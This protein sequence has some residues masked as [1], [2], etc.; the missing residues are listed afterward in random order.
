[1]CQNQSE[2]TS[3]VSAWISG[4]QISCTETGSSAESD[5]QVQKVR[6]CHCC[7]KQAAST[8][9]RGSLRLDSSSENHPRVMQ[10]IF[11]RFCTKRI[12]IHRISRHMESLSCQS[13]QNPKADNNCLSI[14][15]MSSLCPNC[16]FFSCSL[17]FRFHFLPYHHSKQQKYTGVQQTDSPKAYKLHLQQ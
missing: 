15:L 16:R 11:L 14:V 9:R 2:S 7:D 3:N 4:G 10:A 13:R 8:C 6:H 5:S 17:L 12:A 1:M